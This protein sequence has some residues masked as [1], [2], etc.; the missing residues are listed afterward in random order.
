MSQR[1]TQAFL[2]APVHLDAGLTSVTLGI[3][4]TLQRLGVQVGFVKPDGQEKKDISCGMV[5]RIFNVDT[6]DSIQL[7]TIAERIASSQSA[8][9]LEDIVALCMNA[10]KNANILI[11]EGLH[12]DATHTFTSQLNID[13]A[14][15]L[16]A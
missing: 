5:R 14:N 13:I 10:S 12:T 9:V 8:D 16:K 2:V 7:E 4:N 3:V 6:P 15:S 11:I 1:K